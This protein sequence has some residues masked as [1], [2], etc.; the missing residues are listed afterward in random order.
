MTAL[1]YVLHSAAA[2]LVAVAS[3]NAAPPVGQ[4][5]INANSNTGSIVLAIDAAGIVTGTIRLGTEYNPVHGFWN[6]ASSKLT[7][8]RLLGS[9]CANTKL[10][11]GSVVTLCATPSVLSPD[12]TQ[13]FTGYLVTSSGANYLDGS[14]ET[15]DESAGGTYNKNVFGWHA[16]QTTACD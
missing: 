12:D 6:E 4:W 8:Y 1:R 15:F 5:T 7:I 10:P 11:N 14:F 2:M 3:A 9:A 13:V 16:C